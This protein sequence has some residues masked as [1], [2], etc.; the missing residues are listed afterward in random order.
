[1]SNIQQYSGKYFYLQGPARIVYCK[2]QTDDA[3]LTSALALN[4]HDA[5]RAILG[6]VITLSDFER[7][8]PIVMVFEELKNYGFMRKNPLGGYIVKAWKG[9]K[10]ESRKIYLSCAK[11][12]GYIHTLTI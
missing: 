3:V 2:Q 8:Q 7:M 9:G 6:Q 10:A 5:H 4:M 1:M 12:T 11:Q